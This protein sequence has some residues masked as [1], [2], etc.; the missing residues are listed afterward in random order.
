MEASFCRT[1]RVTFVGLTTPLAMRSSNAPVATLHPMLPVLFATFATICAP[2]TMTVLSVSMDRRLAVPRSARVCFITLSLAQGGRRAARLKVVGAPSLRGM[3]AGVP[4][5]PDGT[6]SSHP[7]YYKTHPSS[8]LHGATK[9]CGKSSPFPLPFRSRHTRWQLRKHGLRA[10]VSLSRYFSSA[11]LALMASKFGRVPGLSL[12]SAYW[13]M[14]SL[15]T[16]KAER[17]GT[18]AWPRFFSGRK[19]S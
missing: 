15:S 4:P 13:T 7:P 3:E 11:S 18:P 17:L 2:S 16:R 1:L 14:P 5:T 12:L 10:K 9:P 19:A 8:T 6:R